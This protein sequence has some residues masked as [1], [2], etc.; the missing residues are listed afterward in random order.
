MNRG[1]PFEGAPA[2]G[3]PERRREIAALWRE[4]PRNRYVRASLVVA[5]GLMAVAWLAGGFDWGDFFSPRRAENLG[6]FLNE[7]RPFPLQGSQQDA[8]QQPAWSWRVAWQWAGEIYSDRGARAVGATVG[9]SLIAIL[10]AGFF[11]LALSLPAARSF[12][13]ADAFLPPGLEP[14]RV[15]IA[16]WWSLRTGTRASLMLLRSVPEYVLAFLLLAMLGPT[17]WTAIV[18]L[19]LHNAGILG[20][21]GAESVENAPAG[22]SRALRSLGAGRMRIAV[23][24]FAPELLP[25][26]LLYLFYRWETCVREATVL[27]LLGIVSLGFFISDARARGQMDVLVYFVVLGAGIVLVGELLSTLARELIRRST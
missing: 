19:A 24:S 16:M 4:R 23:W 26:L 17:P 11:G 22:P 21:L 12:A 14:S 20:R 9:I 25:R 5:I 2:D 13:R 6:R 27:G 1:I 18:A 10:L 3:S 15:S 8:L 7:I